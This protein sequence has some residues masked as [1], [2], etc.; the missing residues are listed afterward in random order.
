MLFLALFLRLLKPGGR[1]AVIV[2]E[3]VLFGSSKAHKE[4]RKL[5]VDGHKLEAVVKL[6]SG[7]FKP[8]TGSSTAILSSLRPIAAAP[9][10]CG[11]TRS[12]PKG[13][14][15]DDRR[16]PL[17][18]E[19]KLGPNRPLPW[20]RQTMRRTTCRTFWRDGRVGTVANGTVP[21]PSRV[22][23]C[24]SVRYKQLATT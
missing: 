17:L 19:D 13:F 10:T 4:V 23:A 14:R 3:G 2:P 11:S 16:V 22:S 7:V 15:L 1:A 12:R 5:L 20:K 8:Y 6:P 24:H 9:T 18:A 21:G